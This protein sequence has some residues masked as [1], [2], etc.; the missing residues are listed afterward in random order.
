M[1]SDLKKN[2]FYG[3]FQY[4]RLQFFL[5]NPFIKSTKFS[6]AHGK[7]QILQN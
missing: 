7:N 2:Q 5:I 3:Y 4:L 6:S 1:K